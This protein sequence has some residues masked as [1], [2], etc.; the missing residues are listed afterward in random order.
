MPKLVVFRKNSTLRVLLVFVFFANVKVQSNDSKPLTPLGKALNCFILNNIFEDS[1]GFTGDTLVKTADNYEEIRNLKSGSRVLT[2]NEKTG[3][4]CEQPVRAVSSVLASKIF[5]LTLSD[6]QGVGICVGTKQTF[7]GGNF[8]TDRLGLK[9]DVWMAAETLQTLGSLI[10][11]KLLS[12]S[13]VCLER[14]L[15]KLY[16]IEVAETHN[17]FVTELGV[18]VHNT[19]AVALPAIAKVATTV[20][21]AAALYVGMKMGKDGIDKAGET[22]QS[23]PE[24]SV[25][26]PAP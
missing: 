21:Q 16:Q 1:G 11:N 7:Y 22:Q 6:V 14:K 13:K 3:C 10:D 17:F 25:L 24:V 2:L 12:V 23:T 19:P 8:L 18:L 20:M 15:T 4:L 9:K 26:A 5:C